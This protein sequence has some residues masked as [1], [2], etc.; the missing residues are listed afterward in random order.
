MF[1]AVRRRQI[2]S[3]TFFFF[4]NVNLLYKGEEEKKVRNAVQ[5]RYGY[6]YKVKKG[7]EGGEEGGDD[8]KS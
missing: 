7:K 4:L 2:T 3:F 6:K 1:R 5:E 8:F